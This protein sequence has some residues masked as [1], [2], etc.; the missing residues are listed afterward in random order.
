MVADDDFAAESECEREDACD[1]EGAQADARL[2]WLRAPLL[3]EFPIEA[4]D[5]AEVGA[6]DEW[7]TLRMQ[8]MVL[9]KGNLPLWEREESEG[10]DLFL[11]AR[12]AARF[13]GGGDTLH[14]ASSTPANTA[15]AAAIG[16]FC[17]FSELRPSGAFSFTP[18]F[19]PKRST[20]SNSASI[21]DS[22]TSHLAA[23]DSL[24]AVIREP[25]RTGR[26]SQ[27]T[28]V[29]SIGGGA[30]SVRSTREWRAASSGRADGQ[31]PIERVHFEKVAQKNW[32]PTK[33]VLAVGNYLVTADRSLA[34]IKLD[35]VGDSWDREGYEL[36]RVINL[37][38]HTLSITGAG[39]LSVGEK[40]DKIWNGT[41]ATTRDNFEIHVT[42]GGAGYG[43]L[44]IAAVMV[45]A[46]TGTT[47]LIKTGDGELILSN[48]TKNTFAGE[49]RVE[50][51]TLTLRSKDGAI[52][53]KT[54]FVGDGSGPAILNLKGGRD[55]ID[56][57][58]TVTLRGGEAGEAAVLR[59]EKTHPSKGVS[60]KLSKLVIEGSSVIE[61][62]DPFIT[63]GKGTSPNKNALYIDE[64]DLR[65]E[66]TIRGWDKHDT[67]I[68]IKSSVQPDAELLAKIHVEGHANLRVSQT[69]D[70]YWSL[71]AVPI[72]EPAICGAIV[73]PGVLALA[74]WRRR[75]R[76][77]ESAQRGERAQHT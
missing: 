49:V 40:R 38:K 47:G 10:S 66:L 57:E 12:S 48:Q 51:G 8:R 25:P 77:S 63:D 69:S 34:A 6:R 67:Q 27:L 30:A 61:F 62:I 5:F 1:L 26:A 15:S 2:F 24:G 32:G 31:L 29:F 59:F 9:G 14:L 72:P 39:I 64:L 41:L 58:A 4:L 56:P 53:S 22:D 76:A 73:A 19:S 74:A 45:N 7:E 13:F 23:A 65:G 50:R 70:G 46:A 55:H 3:G 54:I 11:E 75:A 68:F 37:D 33:N 16:F 20:A 18:Q 21:G 36:G 60:Q 52:A 17:D 28:S 44:E 35:G 43:G 71:E 42:G